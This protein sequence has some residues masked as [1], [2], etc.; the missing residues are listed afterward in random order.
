MEI[1]VSHLQLYNGAV[2]SRLEGWDLRVFSGEEIRGQTFWGL[3]D[4][5]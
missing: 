5:F 3:G 2:Y 4:E 1:K